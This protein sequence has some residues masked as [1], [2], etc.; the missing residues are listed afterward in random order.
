MPK[1]YPSPL[2]SA[3]LDKLTDL[4]RKCNA[5]ATADGLAPMY[6]A[7]DGGDASQPNGWLFVCWPAQNPAAT[8]AGLRLFNALRRIA[9]EELGAMMHPTEQPLGGE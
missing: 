5:S 9:A 2:G 7:A 1:T 8:R 6:C 4:A 3:D